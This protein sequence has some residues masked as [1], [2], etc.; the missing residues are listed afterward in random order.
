MKWLTVYDSYLTGL[1]ADK[2]EVHGIDDCIAYFEC[3][4]LSSQFAPAKWNVYSGEG[5]RWQ[6]GP[7]RDGHHVEEIKTLE[8]KPL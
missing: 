4:W 7:E 2:P 5:P 6:E 1:K 3:I 8:S